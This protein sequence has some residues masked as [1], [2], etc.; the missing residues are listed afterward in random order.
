MNRPDPATVH[1]LWSLGY[2][3]REIADALDCEP[4]EVDA[5]ERDSDLDRALCRAPPGWIEARCRRAWM[6]VANRWRRERPADARR[7]AAAP[8]FD[9]TYVEWSRGNGDGSRFLVRAGRV[10]P[11]ALEGERAALAREVEEEF[12]LALAREIGA[13]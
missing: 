9:W 7:L 8:G 10:D 5:A 3:R 1:G 11:D 12:V 4:G 13:L 2:G 6:R